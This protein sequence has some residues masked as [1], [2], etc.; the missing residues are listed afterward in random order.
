M[1]D[2]SIPTVG[3][4]PFQI[5]RIPKDMKGTGMRG[6]HRLSSIPRHLG[7]T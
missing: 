7:A 4:T 3:T 6:N 1:A 5:N 2:N